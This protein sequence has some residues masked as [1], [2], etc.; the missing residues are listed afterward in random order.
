[1]HRGDTYPYDDREIDR[2]RVI[3]DRTSGRPLGT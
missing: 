2:G 1:M 3:I